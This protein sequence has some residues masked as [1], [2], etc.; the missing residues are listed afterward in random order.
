MWFTNIQN[1]QHQIFLQFFW[2]IFDFYEYCLELLLFYVLQSNWYHQ[3][4]IFQYFIQLTFGIIK[5]HSD[6]K[7]T[8]DINT[9]NI[10]E[11]T[12]ETRP[13][14]ELLKINARMCYLCPAF[15]LLRTVIILFYSPHI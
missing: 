4:Q 3:V 9:S 13:D 8:S 15:F 14:K 11:K 7:N 12:L 10:S 1:S 5:N 2:K 6:Y